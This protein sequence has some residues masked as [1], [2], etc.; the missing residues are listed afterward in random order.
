M[1]ASSETGDDRPDLRRIPVSDRPNKVSSGDFAEHLILE[2][3]DAWLTKP[4]RQARLHDALVSYLGRGQA[5]ITRMSEEIPAA[6][7][8]D[9]ASRSLRVLL[10]EDNVAMQNLTE[11]IL[12]THGCEVAV[13]NNG[14]EA[15]QAFKAA[16]FDVV[17]MDCRMPDFDGYA[18]AREIRAHEHN[19]NLKPV[20]ILALTAHAFDDNKKAC[21]DAGMTDFLSK[22]F[23]KRQLLKAIHGLVG[24]MDTARSN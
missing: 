19:A 24:H 18:A 14:R 9:Q 11:T 12:T 15:V 2:D 7:V 1:K 6:A 4:V 3:I 21:I 23:T 16:E 5:G 13:V 17:L 22:P 8:N 20:P 10:A